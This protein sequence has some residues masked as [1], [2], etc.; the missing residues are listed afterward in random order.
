MTLVGPV[1]FPFWWGCFY[2]MRPVDPPRSP[3]GRRWWWQNLEVDA[4]RRM[5]RPGG[6]YDN[7]GA[8][9]GRLDSSGGSIHSCSPMPVG[10]R[11]QGVS[12]TINTGGIFHPGS[13]PEDGAGWSGGSFN[14]EPERPCVGART[15]PEGLI[16]A[17]L[18]VL[19]GGGGSRPPDGV[20]SPPPRA[21]ILPES[22]SPS[23]TGAGGRP[24]SPEGPLCSGHFPPPP[25]GG[26]AFRHRE[27]QHQAGQGPSA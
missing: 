17:V 18:S 22:A 11:V 15:G 8:V 4:S 21:P 20:E 10:R 6:G 27:L 24:G 19:H 23:P 9:P 26:R 2:S 3:P 5:E 1:G 25:P 16:W 12:W 7:H 14:R 13:A